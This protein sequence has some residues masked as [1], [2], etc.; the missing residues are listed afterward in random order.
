M[1]KK[2]ISDLVEFR[3][4]GMT[5]RFLPLVLGWMTGLLLRW[6]QGRGL[7]QS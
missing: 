2:K 6:E 4:Q 3:L 1:E 5:P 7:V